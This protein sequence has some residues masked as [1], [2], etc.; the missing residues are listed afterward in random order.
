[1]SIG[2]ELFKFTASDA[3]AWD[4]FGSSVGISGT[5]AIVGA[6]NNDDPC[7]NSGSAYLYDF[8]DPCNIIETKLTAS[9]A[10]SNDSFGGSVSLSGT[11]ALVSATGDDDNGSSSGSAYVY[12]FSDPCSIIETKLTASDGATGDWFGKFVS[13]GGT[14]ALVGARND[15]DAG[16]SSGSAY[17]FDVSTGVELTKLTASDAAAG[18]AFGESV[19]ISGT[20]AI[21]GAYHDDDAGTSSGSAYLYLFGSSPFSPDGDINE[22]GRV[23][24][25]DFAE[26]ASGWQSSYYMADL[27]KMAA[28]WLVNCI[29]NPSDPACVEP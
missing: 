19:S 24:S 8:S 25:R 3:M 27:A 17:L 5:T 15:D 10:V 4:N 29:V 1:V 22:D 21:V 7:S 16:S 23:E 12:D 9:D 13:L 2:H 18:D 26:L 14:T 11:T 6:H 20:T 28:N